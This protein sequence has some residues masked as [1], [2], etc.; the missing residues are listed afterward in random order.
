MIG[1]DGTV[2]AALPPPRFRRRV[3]RGVGRG[4]GRWFSGPRCRCDG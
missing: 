1:I 2:A 3:G 4:V